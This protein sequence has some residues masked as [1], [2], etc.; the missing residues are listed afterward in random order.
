MRK[1]AR[2]QV[3]SKKVKMPFNLSPRKG[4]GVFY[5]DFDLDGQRVKRSCG[6]N[7]QQEALVIAHA[8]YAQIQTAKN[9]NFQQPDFNKAE[10]M[11]VEEGF[12]KGNKTVWREVK[13]KDTKAVNQNHCIS[14]MGSKKLC[15]ITQNDAVALGEFLSDKGYAPATR[16]KIISEIRVLFNVAVEEWGYNLPIIRWPK[17][18]ENNRRTRTYSDSELSQILETA[19]A[20]DPTFGKFIYVVMYTGAR[21]SEILN[22]GKRDLDFENELIVIA[23]HKTSTSAKSTKVLPM[24]GKVGEILKELAGVC[25][26]GPF[27][28]LQYDT[29]DFFWRKLRAQLGYQDDKE[30][31]IHTLRHSFASNLI[32]GGTDLRLVQRLLGHSDITTTMRYEHLTTAIQ[33]KDAIA[34]LQNRRDMGQKGG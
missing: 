15:E 6:T 11:T 5:V 27:E 34:A 16:N 12:A 19:R 8:I 28:N 25:I 26:A 9:Y 3:S 23:D 18:T 14:F 33:A 24:S 1:T 4:S 20:I 29:V 2:T 17:F 7:N 21:R 13:G 30:F 22:V 31:V 10:G 32:A